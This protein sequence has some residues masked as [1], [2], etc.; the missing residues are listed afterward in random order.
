MHSQ[1]YWFESCCILPCRRI[2]LLYC[3]GIAVL[4]RHEYSCWSTKM[5]KPAKFWSII[6][7]TVH[8]SEEPPRSI[9]HLFVSCYIYV[10][11]VHI[12]CLTYTNITYESWNETNP[13]CSSMLGIQGNGNYT[14][15]FS[16][17]TW[18][19]RMSLSFTGRCWLKCVQLQARHL[20]FIRNAADI[21]VLNPANCSCIFVTSFWSVKVASVCIILDSIM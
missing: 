1:H 11:H 19:T 21:H 16:L 20:V 8:I 6:Y 17:S 2:Y 18:A 12:W 3:C 10:P 7:G 4:A 13:T 5:I 9:Q 14:L 15:S